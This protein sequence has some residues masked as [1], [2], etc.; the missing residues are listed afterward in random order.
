MQ[1][2][3]TH[4]AGTNDGGIMD[5]RREA[6]AQRQ[7]QNEKEVLCVSAALRLKTFSSFPSWQTVRKRI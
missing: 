3:G 1:T 7:K 5:E 2:F 4:R 6:E